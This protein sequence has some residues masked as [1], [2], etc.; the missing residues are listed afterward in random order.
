MNIQDWFPLGLT[1]LTSWTSVL[2]GTLRVFSNTTIQMH[3]FFSV[4]LSLWSN[5]HIHM[6]QLEKNIAL[7]I[8]TFVS[9]MMS[10][11]FNTM[12]GFVKVAFLVA[13]MVKNLPTMQKTQVW[14]LGQKDPLKKGIETHSSIFPWRISWTKELSGLQSMRLQRVGHNWATNTFT[15]KYVVAFLPRSKYLLISWLQSPSAPQYKIKS[16]NKK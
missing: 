10:Y 5:T 7:T 9:K 11:L 16:L 4:Q 12:S 14:S 15:F 2:Q 8:R 6:W 3:Q 13:Q 1:G